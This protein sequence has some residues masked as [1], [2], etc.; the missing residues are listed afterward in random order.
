LGYRVVALVELALGL[1]V[2]RELLEN[3]AA[4][5]CRR[6]GKRPAAEHKRASRAP[7][8]HADHHPLT[9]RRRLPAGADPA[10]R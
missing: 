5:L 10:Y 8:K 1:D 6:A 7:S 3:V 4:P 9:D 2:E